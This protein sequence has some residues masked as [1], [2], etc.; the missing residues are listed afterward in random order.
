MKAQAIAC[1]NNIRQ[2]S[3]GWFL[4]ADDSLDYLLVNHAKAETTARRQSWVNNIEDWG[5][6]DDNTNLLLIT[7]GKL[8]PYV[9]SATANLPAPFGPIHGRQR[10]AHP[11]RFP[12]N[13]CVWAAPRPGARPV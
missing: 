8:A 6:T 3:F 10:A 5:A 11:K 2:L 7:N 9:S 1:G 4:Y 12:L 13:A